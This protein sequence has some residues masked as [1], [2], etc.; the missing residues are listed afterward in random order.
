MRQ[1][2]GQREGGDKVLEIKSSAGDDDPY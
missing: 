2:E 1:K